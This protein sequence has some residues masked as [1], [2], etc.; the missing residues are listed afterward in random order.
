MYK[1]QV[2]VSTVPRKVQRTPIEG[3]VF[4]DWG[5]RFRKAHINA[6]P[7]NPSHQITV[8]MSSVA[9]EHILEQ[10]G[11]AYLLH[12]EVKNLIEDGTLHLVEGAQKFALSTYVAYFR[13][14]SESEAVRLALEG[15]KQVRKM[16]HKNQNQK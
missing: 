7:D 5:Q 13:D 15:L 3:Y 1:R 6:Y 9:L 16:Y 8:T 14:S 4:V 10:G 12:G 2:L 11:S